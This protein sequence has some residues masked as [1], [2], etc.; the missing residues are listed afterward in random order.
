MFLLVKIGVD[1]LAL[2]ADAGVREEAAAASVSVRTEAESFL[3][4]EAV[5]FM[6]L[7]LELAVVRPLV[8]LL[9]SVLVGRFVLL[10]IL[11][12]AEEVTVE[13]G[14]L[15]VIRRSPA[16]TLKKKQDFTMWKIAK[17]TFPLPSL[18]C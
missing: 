13:R 3:A 9:P 14:V 1:I 7:R 15:P 4:L 6:K 18:T 16:E 10:D 12:V 8:R 17:I 5:G 2:R 11:R